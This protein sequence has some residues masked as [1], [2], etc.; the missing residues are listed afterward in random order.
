MDPNTF[1]QGTTTTE[2]EEALRAQLHSQRDDPDMRLARMALD[3]EGG[4]SPRGQGENPIQFL[5][6]NLGGGI[7]NVANAA[8]SVLGN[9]A[10]GAVVA[11]VAKT[12][13]PIGAAAGIV[14]A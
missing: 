5:V 7:K 3:P 11:A 8:P 13:G 6:G 9:P 14:R 10:T 12:P 2:S 4:G 1:V